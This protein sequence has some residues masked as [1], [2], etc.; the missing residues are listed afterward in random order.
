[1]FFL[2]NFDSI[3][4]ESLARDLLARLQD[5][6]IT[7][8][9]LQKTSI[10]K[11]VN[12][13]RRVLSNEEL[14]TLAKGLLKNWKKLVPGL[15]SSLFSISIDDSLQLDSSTTSTNRDDKQSVSASSGNSQSSQETTNGK[16]TETKKSNERPVASSSKSYVASSTSDEYR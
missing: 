15:Y 6:R 12:N 9:I 13:L 2:P 16:S 8:N 5:I 14:S 11:T 4:D 7:L 3:Q 1:M 10:G